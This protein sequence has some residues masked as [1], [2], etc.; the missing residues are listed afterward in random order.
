MLYSITDD[1]GELLAIVE[2]DDDEAAAI[3]N[4]VD[5]GALD[6]F[7]LEDDP[8]RRGSRY[9]RVNGWYYNLTGITVLPLDTKGRKLWDS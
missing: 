2:A 7:A 9:T 4:A 6:S 3:D 5:T 8:P 1:T